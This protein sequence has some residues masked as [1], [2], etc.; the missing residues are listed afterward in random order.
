MNLVFVAKLSKQRE[1]YALSRKKKVYFIYPARQFSFLENFF[2][3]NSV[4]T[5]L[6]REKKC[7]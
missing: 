2:L 6:I 3:F 7:V 4:N 1:K 5:F